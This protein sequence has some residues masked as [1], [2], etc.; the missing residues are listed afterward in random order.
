MEEPKLPEKRNINTGGGN[1]NE[2][3]EG[4]YIQ[5]NV[6]NESVKKLFDAILNLNISNQSFSQFNILNPDDSEIKSYFSFWEKLDSEQKISL[7]LNF[8]KNI[9][10]IY[11][12]K[13]PRTIS[14]KFSP[15]KLVFTLFILFFLLVQ[16]RSY[17]DFLRKTEFTIFSSVAST[18]CNISKDMLI[19][20]P[21]CPTP[22]KTV[23]PSQLAAQSKKDFENY[24]N[25]WIE[26]VV[27]CV[28]VP[29][30]ATK[31]L[32][33]LLASPLK[34]I[35]N[36]RL[37]KEKK[38]LEKENKILETE[39]RTKEQTYNILFS[40]LNYSE[41]SQVRALEKAIELRELK[42][43]AST[44][45]V[46]LNFMYPKLLKNSTMESVAKVANIILPSFIPDLKQEEKEE[47]LACLFP[48]IE[49]EKIAE[50]LKPR[51]TSRNYSYLPPGKD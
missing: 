2:R 40:R 6:I 18:Y 20:L 41:Q 11:A 22:A 33:I 47:V 35:H 50:A 45:A 5:G 38:I 13:T 39:R 44:L 48:N 27:S 42:A 16:Y 8:K 1:Y 4:N 23:K 9:E 51:T 14:T 37:E 30:L 49:Q 12:E 34:A 15:R 36:F 29:W 28:V 10:K 43:L 7:V 32:L 31:I 25:S 24:K 3:I 17:R 26:F 19:P 46:Y 21:T